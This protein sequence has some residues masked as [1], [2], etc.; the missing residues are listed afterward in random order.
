[1]TGDL[2]G[3]G[4]IPSLAG[5]PAVDLAALVR[6][7]QVTPRE[8]V[9]AHV[10]RIQELDG[11][12][13]AF[14]EVF[15]DQAL[16]EAEQVAA[17]RDLADLPL[18]GVPV[19]V[20]DNLPVAGFP[21]RSGSLAT[22]SEPAMH[23][24]EVVARLRAAGAVVVGKTTLSELALWPQTE[25]PWGATRNPWDWSRTA[26]G[27]S[28]GSAA[29]VAAGMVPVAI[30]NDA[31]GSIRIPAAACGVV[32]YKPGAGV[33]P[34]EIGSNSWYGTFVNGV[35]ATTVRDV[36]A[37]ATV[38]ADQRPSDDR[39][40]KQ[41]LNA[42]TK[43]RVAAMTKSPFPAPHLGREPLTAVHQA[44]DALTR[45]SVEVL[46]SDPPSLRRFAL[47]MLARWFTAAWND[48]Q[49]LDRTSLEAR[50]R[51]QAQ[52]GRLMLH[53]RA[54]RERDQDRLRE[55]VAGWF[56]EYDVLLLPATVAP[57]PRLANWHQQSWLSNVR[58][59]FDWVG[60]YI[61][62]WNMAGCPAITVP[63][64]MWS[65]GT[66]LGVQLVARQGDDDRLLA[67]AAQLEQAMPWHR[68]HTPTPAP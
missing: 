61:P 14:V 6:S 43:P 64:G 24:H 35:L 65:T 60:S 57:P 32:G 22:I 59:A 46:D 52:I 39:L 37:V 21:T 40:G 28:G 51:R 54:V 2:G 29:A 8:V 48:S 31:F 11:D 33:V 45:L 66:P 34:A 41:Q 44:R 5:M 12:I 15:A 10:A 67:L 58:L 42:H 38:L 53:L 30:G 7:G 9:V 26:G 20:K 56:Q 62:V 13:G 25:G 68:H 19:A 63:I 4:A 55:V 47:P 36:A 23:D 1:M 27:S 3:S 17:R 50:T 49:A 16:A 18:A